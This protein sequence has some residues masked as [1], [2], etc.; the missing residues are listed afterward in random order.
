MILTKQV[1]DTIH[2]AI[3]T[4]YH[5]YPSTTIL[6]QANFLAAVTK[7]PYVCLAN[8]MPYKDVQYS[9]PRMQN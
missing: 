5:N 8:M 4:K 3:P 7:L 9:N 6:K 2:T 1:T